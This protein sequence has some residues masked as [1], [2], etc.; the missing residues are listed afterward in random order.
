MSNERKW[1][2]TEPVG[3]VSLW[4]HKEQIFALT[5]SSHKF[6]FES[7]YNEPITSINPMQVSSSPFLD[8]SHII[9][10]INLK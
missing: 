3:K 2:R 1:A 8:P 7:C 9:H 4:Q 6:L 5:E 10:F